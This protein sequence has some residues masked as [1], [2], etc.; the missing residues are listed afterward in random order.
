[1]SEPWT[2]PAAALDAVIL[3]GGRGSRLGGRDKASIEVDGESLL[4]RAVDGARSAGCR[5]VVVVGPPR[6]GWEEIVQVREEPAYGGPVAAL[7]AALGRLRSED[8]LLMAVDLRNAAGVARRLASLP[9]PRTGVVLVDGSGADQWL[10][11]R[12]RTEVLRGSLTGDHRDQALRRVLG[13]FEPDRVVV[14]DDLVRDIDTPA[15]LEGP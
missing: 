1:M 7:A 11:S 15:D 2:D 14:G 5:E 13:A 8:V 3:A 10:A 6:A 4:R 9:R 12:W